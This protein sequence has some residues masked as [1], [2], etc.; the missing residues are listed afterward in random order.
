[1]LACYILQGRPIKA[2]LPQWDPVSPLIVFTR[3]CAAFARISLR[4]GQAA[5]LAQKTSRSALLHLG[6]CSM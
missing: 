6:F 5:W 1:M 3:A 2:F 4:E